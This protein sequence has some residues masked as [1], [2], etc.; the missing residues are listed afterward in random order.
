ME[1]QRHIQLQRRYFSPGDD[2]NLEVFQFS[3]NAPGTLYE[4]PIIQYILQSYLVIF[5]LS[6]LSQASIL[7]KKFQDSFEIL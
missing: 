7:E 1:P 3:L 2:F 5:F 6:D 4:K